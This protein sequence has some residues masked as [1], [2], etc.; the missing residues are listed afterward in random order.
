ML[1]KSKAAALKNEEKL[2]AKKA[3]TYN[4]DG[5]I[6]LIKKNDHDRLPTTISQVSVPPL[7]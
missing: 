1:A 5:E 3:Y 6:I 7:V 2:L 4:Y